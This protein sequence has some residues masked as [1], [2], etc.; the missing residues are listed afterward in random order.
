MEKVLVVDANARLKGRKLATIDVI[1]VGPRLVT[2][3]LKRYGFEAVLQPYENVLGNKNLMKQFN[4]LAISFM[5]S[6][7]V[8]VD[9]LLNQWRKI[10]DGKGVAVLGGPG[11]LSPRVL[12]LLDFDLAFLGEVEFVFYE[13]F[14]RRGFK[15]FKE[16]A[17][18]IVDKDAT[19]SGIAVKKNNQVVIRGLAPWT[20]KELLFSVIPEVNDIRNYPFFWA[21]RVYVETVRGCSNFKRPRFTATGKECT[22]CGICIIGKLSERITCP[23]GIPPGCGY[24]S[25]PLIHGYPRSRD[26]YSIL[27]EVRRLLN[28]GVTRVVLSAPDFLDYCREQKVEGPLT[29]PCN[30][31]PNLEA[32]E[33]LLKDITN[34][35]AVAEGKASILVENVKACLLDEYVAELLGRYLRGSAIYIGLESCSDKLLEAIGR[36]SK[37]ADVLKAIEFLSKYGL[38]PYVYIMHRI[39]MEDSE[40]ISKTIDVIPHLEK[41]GVER[42]VLYRFKPLPRTAFEIAM[43]N[44]NAE[45]IKYV[46]ELKA[47]VKEFNEKAKVKLLGKIIDVVIASQYPRNKRYLV[48]Y[49]LKHGPVVLIKASKNF[50]GCI[51]RVRITKVVSDRIVVGELISTRYRIL[52]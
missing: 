20:P 15:S 17:E 49:P 50:I 39:P 35:E 26:P 45:Y 29:D 36:P 32:I 47:K 25:V 8:A 7:T 43:D 31:S 10:K 23:I 14:Y 51:A 11:V 1:G 22:N 27:E 42:I 19:L 4:V 37:C 18:Q 40:D 33:K 24:C 13:L 30:P 9:K 44:T 28:I 48:A 5:V 6:D 2:A 38:K 52:H 34:L 21:C 46:E 3:L 12:D 16:I 41:L